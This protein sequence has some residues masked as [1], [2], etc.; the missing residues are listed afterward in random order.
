MY[1]VTATVRENICNNDSSIHQLVL[2]R[3]YEGTDT[4]Y[5]IYRLKSLADR[6]SLYT[7]AHG[8]HPSARVYINFSTYHNRWIASTRADYTECNNLRSLPIFYP[9]S[10]VGTT[11]YYESCP[12]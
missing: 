2:D 12:L 1:K 6:G 8:S 3:P 9:K 5:D 7:A 11:T 10:K 4:V